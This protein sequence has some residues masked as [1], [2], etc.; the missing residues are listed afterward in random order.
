[1]TTSSVKVNTQFDYKN[2]HFYYHYLYNILLWL[3]ISQ[4]TFLKFELH[5]VLYKLHIN[6]KCICT[7]FGKNNKQVEKSGKVLV[8]YVQNKLMYKNIKNKIFSEI[9]SFVFG[10]F[11]LKI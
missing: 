6:N 1:M 3:N 7:L 9:I 8:T 2:H 4:I 11:V 5:N 10:R